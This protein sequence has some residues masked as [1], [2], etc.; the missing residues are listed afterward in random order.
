MHIAI[1]YQRMH[2][3]AKE[4]RFKEAAEIK[5]KLESLR[6]KHRVLQLKRTEDLRQGICHPLGQSWDF[7][8][9]PRCILYPFAPSWVYSS[10]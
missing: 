10:T 3:A 7:D 8:S 5:D 1:A 4:D 6:L 9:I 2:V